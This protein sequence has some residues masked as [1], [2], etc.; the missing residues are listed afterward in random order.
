MRC[1]APAI[2]PP[3]LVCLAAVPMS[4]EVKVSAY[5]EGLCPGG[6]AT[7]TAELMEPLKEGGAP[8]EWEWS[9]VPEENPWVL[10][11]PPGTLVA[12]PGG[13]ARYTA[14]EDPFPLGARTIGVRVHP[15][16]QAGRA[17][18]KRIVIST[19]FASALFDR[20]PIREYLGVPSLRH[21]SLDLVAGSPTEPG[22]RLGRGAEARF[23][24]ITAMAWTGDHPD[25]HMAR[26]W[27]VL[28]HPEGADRIFALDPA[29]GTAWKWTSQ[30][31]PSLDGQRDDVPYQ[32]LAVRPEG[33]GPWWAITVHR[34]DCVIRS[35]DA[36]A[37]VGILAGE[38]DAPGF[39]DGKAGESRFEPPLAATIGIDGA[40]YVADGGNAVIRK[41]FDGQVTTI[42]GRAGKT[43]TRDGIGAQARFTE[44]GAIAQDPATGHLY[45]LDNTGPDRSVREI[46]LE[47]EVRTL[48]KARTLMDFE[49]G[50]DRKDLLGGDAGDLPWLPRFGAMAVHGGR[51]YIPHHNRNTIEVLHLA[52]GRW[53]TLAGVLEQPAFSP[54]ALGDGRMAPV[55]KR[56]TLL[57]P[58]CVA[59][60]PEGHCLLSMGNAEKVPG[61]GS[62]IAELAVP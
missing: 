55:G 54:G 14:P 21:P 13:G 45:V 23:G 30:L 43:G 7:L 16:G 19:H 49:P 57:P 3:A 44:P 31:R 11:E 51:L 26:K 61:Q 33:L 12:T 15:R 60:N 22:A 17:V 10:A 37:D 52:S 28:D 8:P 59:V 35:L 27:L 25:E 9:L 2:L 40:V 42:A 39:K 36:K 20:L 5:P 47:G 50:Y 34:R 56:A 18:V 24:I 29:D 32:A 6:T 58:Y 4:A 62:C 1:S 38:P 46:T 53:A 48:R 41:C